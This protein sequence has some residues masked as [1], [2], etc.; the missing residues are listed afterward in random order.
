MSTCYII[1]LNSNESIHLFVSILSFR[2][3]SEFNQY[4]NNHSLKC[5]KL[6]DLPF[7]HLTPLSMGKYLDPLKKS[8]YLCSKDGHS[9]SLGTHGRNPKN[10]MLHCSAKNRTNKSN[11]M[12]PYEVIY[13]LFVDF[14]DSFVLSPTLLKHADK[15]SVVNLLFC[16]YYSV[17]V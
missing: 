9:H 8:T 1:L 5:N 7:R 3:K 11:R 6:E 4:S 13:F 15:V 14:Y 16:R 12:L 10:N 17:N 2:Y